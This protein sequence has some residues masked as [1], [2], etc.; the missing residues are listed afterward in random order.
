[1]CNIIESQEL[2]NYYYR[3]MQDNELER[4]LVD[5]DI[6]S[7]MPDLGKIIERINSAEYCD[8]IPDLSIYANGILTFYALYRL[9]NCI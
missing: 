3:Q 9:Q 2:F 6:D 5:D 8:I 4:Q 1:M 7:L